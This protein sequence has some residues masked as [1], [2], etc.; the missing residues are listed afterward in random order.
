M[1]AGKSCGGLST[2]SVAPPRLTALPPILHK[3]LAVASCS[4]R[5]S[6]MSM[7][8][9]KTPA[10]QEKGRLN[11]AVAKWDSHPLGSPY[12]ENDAAAFSWRLCIACRLGGPYSQQIKIK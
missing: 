10:R 4:D 6:C 3:H 8:S 2:P 5:V 7:H 9:V 11:A 12:F 1:S